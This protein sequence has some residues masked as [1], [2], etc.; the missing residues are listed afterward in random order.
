MKVEINMINVEDGDAIIVQLEKK[1][2]KALIVIDG[3]YKGHYK[4]LKKRLDELIPEY[5]NTINLV[6]CT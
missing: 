1:G 2:E 4:K 5:K 3:G 6:I